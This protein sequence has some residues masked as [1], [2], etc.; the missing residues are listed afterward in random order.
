MSKLSAIILRFILLVAGESMK[1]IV[2]L[3]AEITIKSK[4]V[5]QRH[6]KVLTG[7]IRTLLKPLHASMRV[8]NHWDRIEVHHDDEPQLTAATIRHLGQIPGIAYFEQVVEH[9]LTD[10]A[11]LLEWMLPLQTQRL[12]G[13]TFAVRVKRKGRHEFSSMDMAVYLGGGIRARVADTK[14]QLKNPQEELVIHVIEDQVSLVQQR[15]PGLGGFPLPTQETVLSLMSGGFDSAVASFQMI[16]RGARTHFCFFN[17]G[18]D[19]HEVAVRE[20][21]Y[22]LWEKYSKTHAVKFVT[23]DFSEV[24]A[25]ILEAGDQG[26]L[27]VL[28]KRAMMRAAGQVA[29][30]L[31]AQ[32]IVTGEAVGQVSSQTLSNLQ[33]IDQ[34]TDALILRPLIVQDKQMI[35][36]CARAIGVEA[37]SAAVPEY[38]GVISK[39]PSVKV[40]PEVIAATEQTVL[41]D[42]L[43]ANAVAQCRVIDIRDAHSAQQDTLGPPVIRSSETLPADAVIVDVRRD[44]EQ[45]ESP[46]EVPGHKVLHIPFFRLASKQDMLDKSKAYFLYCDQ[47]VMSRLQAVQLQEQGFDRVAIY[48][49]P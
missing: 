1:F 8:R 17:L 16:R 21:A 36:D 34:S 23:V 3:H 43:I 25:Q 29:Q 5:R 38:C 27:G 4:S 32:A 46:L 39:Q 14:V 49:R 26:T 33:L 24:V 44:E 12:Q 30:R 20:I 13:K 41:P 42:A 37:L 45:E 15:F 11:E 7:N 19:A 35:V 22:F 40:R 2:R 9:P 47:G 48:E 31:N 28:L 10:F 6:L 18:A